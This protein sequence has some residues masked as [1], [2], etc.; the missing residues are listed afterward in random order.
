MID[1]WLILYSIG[2]VQGFFLI[3]LLLLMKKGRKLTIK[4]LILLLICPLTLIIPKFFSILFPGIFFSVFRSS[5]AI[6]LLIG[7]IFLLYT[8]SVLN[9]NFKL[10]KNDILHFTPFLFFFIFFLP[11]SG[12]SKTD[13]NRVAL[14]SI[15]FSWLKGLHSFFYFLICRFYINKFRKKNSIKNN[16]N[17]TLIHRFVIF[18]LIVVVIVYLLVTLEYLNPNLNIE[19][20]RISAFIFTFSYFFFAL[21]LVLYPK[22]LIPE[23]EQIIKQN[24]YQKSTLNHKDKLLILKNL[25]KTLKEEKPYLNPNLSLN[26]LASM[27]DINSNLLSQVI[28]ELLNKNFFQLINEYRVEEIK[29]NIGDTKKTFYG[30]A[31]DSGFNSK[32][33]FN[34]IFKDYTGLTPSQYKKSIQ[35]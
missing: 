21:I 35:K 2:I 29:S 27:I 6:P 24:R 18:Q 1:I 25:E 22:D 5:E 30:I 10:K 20:D 26:H 33:A 34:R 28:N 15:I 16:F 3:T 19:P 8:F 4:L 11:Y 17:I 7:P 31:L 23:D 9:S 14:I 12:F 32:S 13:I